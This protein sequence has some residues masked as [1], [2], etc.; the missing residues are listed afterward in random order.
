[1]DG[2]AGGRCIMASAKVGIGSE[3][4]EG[5]NKKADLS[6]ANIGWPLTMEEVTGK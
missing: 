4:I 6:K 2:R 3:E 5:T 1:M